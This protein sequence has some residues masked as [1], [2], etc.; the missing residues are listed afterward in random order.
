MFIGGVVT[1]IAALLFAVVTSGL[2]TVALVAVGA[3][4]FVYGLRL[5][6]KDEST[7]PGLRAYH[8]KR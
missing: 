7:D 2:L 8:H 5:S 1:V 4:L 6:M 3:V